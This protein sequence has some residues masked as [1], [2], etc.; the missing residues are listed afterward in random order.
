MVFNTLNIDALVAQLKM[1][2]IAYHAYYGDKEMT[3][4]KE[5]LTDADWDSLTA[6]M[7]DV[8]LYANDF[9]LATRKEVIRRGK[10]AVEYGFPCNK[11]LGELT[12]DE[13][14]EIAY[15]NNGWEKITIDSTRKA[16]P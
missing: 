7:P 11:T 15:L 8:E 10:E 1:N 9:N 4:C 13:L 3:F 5:E 16:T 14:L 12:D 6:A 2:G